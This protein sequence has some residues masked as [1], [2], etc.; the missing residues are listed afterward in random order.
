MLTTVTLV[1]LGA[2]AIAITAYLLERTERQLWQRR[3]SDRDTD[4][5]ILLAQVPDPEPWQ[6]ERIVLDNRKKSAPNYVYNEPRDGT[7]G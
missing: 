3:Y 7:E 2:L 1:T 6:H 4:Y 5:K